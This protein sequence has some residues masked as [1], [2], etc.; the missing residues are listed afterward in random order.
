LDLLRLRANKL[1]GFPIADAI[2]E[3]I[4]TLPEEE[5]SKLLT[6]LAEKVGG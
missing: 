2:V 6:A 1:E 3:K 4:K 5:A